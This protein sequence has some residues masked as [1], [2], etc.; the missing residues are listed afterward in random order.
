MNL[1]ILSVA[2]SF[3]SAVYAVPLV[4]NSTTGVSY[5]GTLAD[6]VEQFQN[7]PF[8]QPTSGER[9]FAPPQ[10]YVYPVNST[11]NATIPGA[12]CPQPTVP[13]PG[14]DIFSNVTNMSEDCLNLRIAR[15]AN[16]SADD[17]LPVMVW[18]YGGAY[19]I[20]IYIERD[21][22]LKGLGLIGGFTFGNIYD[23]LYT[24]TGLVQQAAANGRPV[25]YVA[26]NYRLNSKLDFALLKTACL[27]SA[28]VFGFASSDAL[29]N[30]GSLNAGLKDQ[31]LGIT[32][33]KDNIAAFG[34]DPDNITLFGESAGGASVGYQLIAYG[35]TRGASFHRAIMESGSVAAQAGVNSNLST[36]NYAA[37]ATM[38]NC[39]RG[40]EGSTETL[41]CLRNLSMQTLLDVALKH[42][43]T[44][45]PP[46]GFLV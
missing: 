38:T 31:R 28:Q 6:G 17:K 4:T 24:P 30:M 25:I 14:T 16:T 27:I 35:G 41:E 13:I 29:R 21:F 9:R 26:I 10:P 12:A 18:I 11:V 2:F 22:M 37:V 33:V 15:P 43:N 8:G 40:D 34:G 1:Q 7:I 3:I 23:G 5:Q 46:F 20:L 36:I 19:F 39:T 42:A 45:R 32:W 44:A